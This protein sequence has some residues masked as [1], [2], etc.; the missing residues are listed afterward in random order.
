[1][2]IPPPIPIPF[3][4]DNGITASS[5]HPSPILARIPPGLAFTIPPS[6]SGVIVSIFTG[7]IPSAVAPLEA[8]LLTAVI[9]LFTIVMIELIESFM[10]FLT[11]SHASPTEDQSAAQRASHADFIGANACVKTVFIQPSQSLIFPFIPH[12]VSERKVDIVFQVSRNLSLINHQE[13]DHAIEI[14]AIPI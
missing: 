12:Q 7:F 5:S 8:S 3:I 13:T 10:I 9:T 2:V 4:F 1:M 6:A 11:L 14:A